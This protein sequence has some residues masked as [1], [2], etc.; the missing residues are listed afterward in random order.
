MDPD[1]DKAFYKAEQ[2][3]QLSATSMPRRGEGHT[4]SNTLTD[5]ANIDKLARG[6]VALSVKNASGSRGVVTGLLA[7]LLDQ[8]PQDLVFEPDDE[9]NGIPVNSLPD[10]ILV[11]I[12]RNLDATS[13][14]RFAVV[15]RKARV[16]SLDLGI[17]RCAI[18]HPIAD[19]Q[20]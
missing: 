15:N 14:E 10:E 1:V 6:V 12:L 19:G 18:Q 20:V 3:Q 16:V 4:K 2:Q 13:I 11:L 5:A 9:K 7:S 8:F 17:W